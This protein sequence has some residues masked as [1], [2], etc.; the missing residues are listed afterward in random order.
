MEMLSGGETRGGGSALGGAFYPTAMSLF[1]NVVVILFVMVALTRVLPVRYAFTTAEMATLYAMMTTGTAVAGVDMVQVLVPMT[2]Y[3]AWFASA[4]NDWQNLFNRF[5][6]SW[7]VVHDRTALE[8]F[9]RGASTLYTRGHLQAWLP[10]FAAWMGFLTAMLVVFGCLT[11]LIRRQWI[12]HERLA[13]PI[14]Q[15]PLALLDQT[16]GLLRSRL[17]WIGFGVTGTITLYNGVAYLAPALPLLVWTTNVGAFFRESP[18]SAIGWTPLRLFPFVIAMVFL[19]PQE[20]SF[21]GWFFY[22]LAKALRVIAAAVGLRGLPEFPYARHQSFGAYFGIFAFA[23]FAGRRHFASLW[24]QAWAQ[25]ARDPDDPVSMRTALLGVLLGTAFLVAFSMKAGLAWWVSVAFFGLYFVLMTGISRIRAELGAPVH[26]LHFMGPER[27]LVLAGGS[28]R[29]GA[30][31]LSLLSV[32]YWFNRAYRCNPMPAQL[33]GLKLAQAERFGARGMFWALLGAGVLGGLSAWWMLLHAFYRDGGLS[34][35]AS[36]AVGAFG[37]EPFAR[38]ERWL[39]LPTETD[40][41][42]LVA[43]AMGYV[44]AT[45]LLVLRTRFVW[46]PLHPLGYC[47]AD[48]YAMNW[49]W[50]SVLSG[51]ALKVTV[52]RLGGIYAYR[53]ALPL[54]LGF[55]MGEFTGGCFWSVVSLITGRPMYAF[56]NW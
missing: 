27:I 49:I 22:W 14:V 56:K 26:D 44:V 39:T 45:A 55:I 10:V 9:Y 29:L 24:R 2:A 16:N 11:A 48:D 15:L 51:W 30:Q 42:A 41:P 38:L 34:G 43:L 23:M 32:F 18:W 46:W 19:I 47:L 3:P 6:P 33:E 50:S 28:R 20:L 5:L 37:R 1:F 36:Y 54:F 25:R 40:V 4:E 21:S 17:F 31:N 53:F 8:G 35:I 52:L 12:E 7:W 13:Y